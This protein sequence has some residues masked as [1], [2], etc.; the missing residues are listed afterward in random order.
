MS[1]LVSWLVPCY[2]CN[3]HF[4][5]RCIQ[6]IQKQTYHN[7]HAVL[8]NDGSTDNRTWEQLVNYA[9]LDK[10]LSCHYMPHAGT[11]AALN[12]GLD[13]CGD[14]VARIDSDDWSEEN[15]LEIQLQ[16]MEQN[17]LDLVGSS[18]FFHTMAQTIVRQDPPAGDIR[19]LLSK[20]Q[21]PIWHPTWV[22]KKEK[23]GYY[24]LDYLHAE[25]F[26][27]LCKVSKTIKAANCPNHLVHKNQH[28]QRVSRLYRQE[29]HEAA[30]RAM[31]ELL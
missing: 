8:V 30:E 21:M 13:F 24:P 31:K 16:Y 27:M 18:M 28:E 25:D 4:L 19:E 23:M 20:H 11:A 22:F 5:R 7:W 3:P 26:A 29:Q 1:Q 6:S 12:H 15:R 14:I 17:G 9:E 2:N 10:R